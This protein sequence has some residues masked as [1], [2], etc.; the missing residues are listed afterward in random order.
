[1]VVILV[2]VVG[3]AGAQEQASPSP[4]PGQPTIQVPPDAAG[5]PGLTLAGGAVSGTEDFRF[6]YYRVDD[7]LPDFEDRRILDY[8]EAVERLDLTGGNARLSVNLRGDAVGLFLN[9]YILDGTLYHER[10]LYQLGVTSPF[11]DALFVLEK[12]NVRSRS[13]H[14]VVDVG[15]TYAAYGRGL[16]LNVVKNTDIDVDTSIRGLKAQVTTGDWEVG[17]LT[18]VTNP[19]QVAL[20]NPNVGIRPDLNH[21]ITAARVARYG[22]GP[23]NVAAQGALF[24]FR[25]SLVYAGEG[26]QAYNQPV[27]AASYGASVE[28]LGVAGLDWYAEGAGYHYADDAIAVDGGYAGYLAATA[29]PGKAT[30]LVELRRNK[31][32]E[33]INTFSALNSYEVSNG[34]T[35]E[36]DRVITEDSA[37]AVNSNDITGGRVR[38][39]FNLSRTRDDGHMTTV[40]PYV[41]V[42]VFRDEDLGSLH[43]NRAPETILHP[44]AGLQFVGGE[45]HLLLNTGF[46]LDQRDP[47]PD[48]L[49]LGADQMAHV[50]VSMDFPL[51]HGVSLA[52]DPT[53]MAFQ[54]G[55]NPIQQTDFLDVSNALA[56]KVGS[57]WAFILYTDFSDNP[58][59]DSTGN[60][61][62]DVYGA[63]EAQWK[64]GSATTLKLFYGAYRAGIRCAGGQCRQLPGFNGAKFSL[65][66]SF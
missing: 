9:R 27:N 54:W 63:L 64:P 29:Y 12:I 62:E 16:V 39:E 55:N 56:V 2:A 13:Q 3:I 8:A 18:G 10:D 57:P 61:S 51:A 44:T 48:G 20:E 14:L 11:P 15:D 5:P 19:Q 60:I 7:R 59:I 1:M 35:L 4:Q 28:A 36:Y 37:A 45:T 49:D 22:V 24:Q 33:Y 17:A 23:L 46:R 26:L 53:L 58:L 40:I 21:V 65:S 30:L 6:R 50:D 47:G 52:I 25:D 32:T 41:S 34:P 66:T 38:A 31:N 42:A 43:F